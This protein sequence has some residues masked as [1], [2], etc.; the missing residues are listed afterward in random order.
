MI[1]SGRGTVDS[2]GIEEIKNMAEYLTAP[3]AVSYMHNDAYPADHPLLSRPNRL[4][5][6]KG[7][8]EY[9]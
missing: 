1:I 4:H 7:C 8:H 2:D 9:T 6:F 3:V 5:G